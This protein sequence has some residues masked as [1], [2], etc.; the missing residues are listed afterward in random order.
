[1]HSDSDTSARLVELGVAALHEASGRRGLIEGV[2][3]IVGDPFAGPAVTV[4]LPAGDNLGVHLVKAGVYTASSATFSPR[5]DGHERSS[6][7]S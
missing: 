3:L 6:A 5:R 7:S 4:A 1:M 2:H